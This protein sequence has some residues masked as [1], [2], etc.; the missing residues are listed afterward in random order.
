MN[1]RQ[2]NSGDTTRIL[3]SYEISASG[4]YLFLEGSD[5]GDI[6]TE[7]GR[8]I[9]PLCLERR[10]QLIFHFVSRQVSHQPPV[11]NLKKEL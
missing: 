7:T 2:E 4:I 1:L 8:I 10:S 5:Q 6:Q 3:I 9:C 11:M